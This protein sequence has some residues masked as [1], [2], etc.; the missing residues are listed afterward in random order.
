MAT[1]KEE[2]TA[3]RIDEL[4]RFLP[5]LEK[6]GRKFIRRCVGGEQPD[7]SFQI[8][9]PIYYADVLKFFRT[10]SQ[11]WWCD[12]KY[13]PP[14]AG[15]MLENRRLV[16]KATLDQVKT[17][18]TYCARSERFCD[19]F[20]ADVLKSGKVFALLKRLKELRKEM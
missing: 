8:P 11:P 15:K 12:Y 3:K 1:N 14:E 17:M 2:L 18:L 19:G 10:A 5:R 6:P 20:W 13:N 7:G 4:L 9:C 16:K